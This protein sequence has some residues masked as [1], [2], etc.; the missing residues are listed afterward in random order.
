MMLSGTLKQ[1]L[2]FS[3]H[4]ARYVSV[5]ILIASG[6]HVYHDLDF[7][8][9]DMQGI[10]IPHYG[11]IDVLPFHVY[12]SVDL[13]RKHH[14]TAFSLGDK[15]LDTP[16]YQRVVEGAYPIRMQDNASYVLNFRG[17]PLSKECLMIEKGVAVDLYRCEK[18]S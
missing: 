4:Y 6:W 15:W 5:V 8:L 10:L 3:A 18:A 11:E 2:V 9:L 7:S 16:L 17:I 12:E 13:L 1:T 14:V